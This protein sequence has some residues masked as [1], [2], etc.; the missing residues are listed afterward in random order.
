MSCKTY[1]VNIDTGAMSMWLNTTF[2]RVWKMNGKMYGMS[3]TGIYLIEGNSTYAATI[4][5]APTDFSDERNPI[6]D[7]LKRLPY[8]SID[9]GGVSVLTPIFDRALDVPHTVQFTD[10]MRVK[11]GRSG[12]G[13][14]IG[15]KIT[16]SDPLFKLESI[17]YFPE[18]LTRRV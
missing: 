5:I 14:Y 8:A 15:M 9:G 16:S 6:M 18:M 1:L 17:R 11:F 4:E 7:N 13:R 10:N 12:K 2:Q 3:P